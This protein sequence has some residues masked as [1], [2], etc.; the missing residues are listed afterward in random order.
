MFLGKKVQRFKKDIL[1][2]F[3]ELFYMSSWNDAI[4]WFIIF[5]FVLGMFMAL[6]RALEWYRS[7]R[8]P[9]PLEPDA[10]EYQDISF[11]RDR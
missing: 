7:V 1:Q 5:I 8:R 2:S 11:R 4:G 6:I 10:Y 3:S 9:D